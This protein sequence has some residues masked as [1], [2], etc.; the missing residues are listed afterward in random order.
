VTL[1]EFP[2]M[3]HVFQ[4]FTRLLPTARRAIGEVGAFIATHV[5]AARAPSQSKL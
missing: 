5:P 3:P 1:S 2:G 4:A